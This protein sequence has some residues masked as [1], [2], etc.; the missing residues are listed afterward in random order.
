[1]MRESRRRVSCLGKSRLDESSFETYLGHFMIWQYKYS[2]VYRHLKWSHHFLKPVKSPMTLNVPRNVPV[3]TKGRAFSLVHWYPPTKKYIFIYF[4]F[5]LGK[6]K[7]MHVPVAPIGTCTLGL[8][9]RD[10]VFNICQFS[11]KYTIIFSICWVKDGL[12][13]IEFGFGTSIHTYK[14]PDLS[15]LI[16]LH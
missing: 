7:C 11:L 4:I 9:I 15:E 6:C 5:F 13:F 1:M 12:F 14:G 2:I 10:V 8:T 16:L 3:H